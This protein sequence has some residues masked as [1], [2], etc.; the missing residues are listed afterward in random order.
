MI[1]N[2]VSTIDLSSY[3]RLF[4]FGC[5][6]TGYIWPTW[7]DI[8]HKEMPNA[9]HYNYGRSG[10]GQLFI[11]CML[12]EANQRHNF[13]KDDLIIVQWSTFFREDRYIKNWWHTPGNIFTQN[14]YDEKFIRK[15]TDLRGYIIRDL[16]LITMSK[17]MLQALPSDSVMLTSI[18][19][20]SELSNI[21][22]ETKI[23]DVLEL[24]RDTI[25]CM[26]TPMT[27]ALRPDGN[28]TIFPWSTNIGYYDLD[29]GEPNKLFMDYHPGP[30]LYHEYLK[31]LNFPLTEI[32]R[33][34]ADVS[35]NYVHAFRTRQEIAAWHNHDHPQ[36]KI[37]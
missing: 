22:P 23:D 33:K 2:D 32:S 13:D 4:T 14:M 24:Y 26:Q 30:I 36:Q 9:T 17:H 19:I 1:I 5:S 37:L 34:Y 31:K 11:T 35:E 18:P 8:L 10:A 6:F 27:E 29:N 28:N 21:E 12:T 16:S 3:K 25:D 20:T 15:F 7:A